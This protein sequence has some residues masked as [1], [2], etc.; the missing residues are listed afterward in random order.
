MM[1]RTIDFE[2]ARRVARRVVAGGGAGISFKIREMAGE[3]K[4]VAQGVPGCWSLTRKDGGL[5][6]KSFDALG[7]ND[8]MGFVDGRKVFS[9]VRVDDDQLYG[10][11]DEKIREMAYDEDFLDDLYDGFEVMVR[12]ED[13]CGK[14]TIFGGYSRGKLSKGD[15]ISFSCDA[16]V[17]MESPGEELDCE[18][19]VLATVSEKGQYWYE[20]VFEWTCPDTD[21]DGQPLSEDEKRSEDEAHGD[22][23]HAEYTSMTAAAKGAAVGAPALRGIAGR[24]ASDFCRRIGLR[25]AATQVAK[26][27]CRAVDGG[28]EV[29]CWFDNPGNRDQFLGFFDEALS[30]TSEID[31]LAK[32]FGMV[33]DKNTMPGGKVGGDR[34][35]VFPFYYKAGGHG[36]P[37]FDGFVAEIK[38]R[39]G[40]EEL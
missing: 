24:V 15:V 2:K 38:S 34:S 25:V 30:L 8:G 31:A 11:V 10:M 3:L 17:D 20:D 13:N 35:V 19:G 14:A 36:E 32:K 7:Y 18:L 5:A 26:V 9:D 28:V 12:F 40:A 27:G 37:D 29:Y 39:Y 1:K 22:Y 6:I 33:C 4:Y 23:C 16:L 21:A